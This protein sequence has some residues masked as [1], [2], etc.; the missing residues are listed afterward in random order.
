VFYILS[1]AIATYLWVRVL[2]MFVG[3]FSLVFSRTRN[4]NDLIGDPS[5]DNFLCNRT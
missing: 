2:R 4:V 5:K 1:H 3:G